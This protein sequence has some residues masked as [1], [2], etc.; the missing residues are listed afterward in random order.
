MSRPVRIV[1]I[2]FALTIAAFL[3]VFAGD[4]DDASNLCRWY[5]DDE[6]IPRIEK[7]WPTTLHVYVWHNT[8]EKRNDAFM[9]REMAQAAELG[10]ES[11]YVETIWWKEGAD[12]GDFSVGLGDF[13]DSKVK[14]PGGLRALS[15]YFHGIGPWYGQFAWNV[16]KDM[17]GSSLLTAGIH[18]LDTLLYITCG[19]V[20]AELPFVPGPVATPPAPL[21]PTAVQL[22]LIARFSVFR[23]VNSSRTGSY[24]Y[25]SFSRSVALC[26]NPRAS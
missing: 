26:S 4:W 12:P 8:P 16:K 5:V 18:S 25:S 13:E 15:D 20:G 2:L 22:R 11:T 23:C 19:Q 9:R 3:G 17:G 6:I 24:R 7:P 14:C 21:R 1:L 10:Y